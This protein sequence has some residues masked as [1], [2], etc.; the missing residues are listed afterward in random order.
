MNLVSCIALSQ[1]NE[2]G[3]LRFSVNKFSIKANY[4]EE[5][6]LEKIMAVDNVIYKKKEIMYPFV[7]EGFR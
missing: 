7:D 2:M 1:K 3:M 4:E 6:K 5:K